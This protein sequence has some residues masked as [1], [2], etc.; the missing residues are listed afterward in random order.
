VQE[1][2]KTA[3]LFLAVVVAT[4]GVFM[5]GWYALDAI[6]Q[7]NRAGETAN[8]ILQEVLR[9]RQQRQAPPVQQVPEEPPSNPGN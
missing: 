7:R 8:Q 9:E 6:E 1:Q 3:L 5:A 4:I 2:L